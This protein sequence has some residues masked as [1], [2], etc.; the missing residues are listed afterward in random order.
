MNEHPPEES[1]GRRPRGR[2]PLSRFVLVLVLGFVASSLLQLAFPGLGGLARLSILVI[3][4]ALISLAVSLRR[5]RG[6]R[7]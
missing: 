7:R 5:Q 4:A 1:A 2:Y 3:V 6:I